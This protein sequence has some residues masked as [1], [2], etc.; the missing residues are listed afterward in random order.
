MVPGLGHHLAAPSASRP[1]PRPGRQNP[2][3]G[4]RH[5]DRSG[6][7]PRTLDRCPTARVGAAGSRAAVA[8]GEHPWAHTGREGDGGAAGAA[9]QDAKWAAN[10][11]AARQF[12]AREGHLRVPRKHIEQVALLDAEAGLVGRQNGA[13]EAVGVKLGT[14][15]DNVR[16]RAAKLTEQRR[17]D[18]DTPGM[19][20]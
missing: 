8:A 11:A 10:L 6:R 17:T 18:L 4:R 12:H 14:W 2:P 15:L 19:R 7:R 5:G 9:G 1:G 13:N 20:W 16:K 3:G